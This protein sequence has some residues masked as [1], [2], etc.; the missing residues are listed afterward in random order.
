MPLTRENLKIEVKNNVRIGL[1]SIGQITDEMILTVSD[2]TSCVFGSWLS[3]ALLL[4][5]LISF[6]VLLC[7][8]LFPVG[9][10]SDLVHSILDNGKSLTHFI[11]FHILL[12][13]ELISKFEQIIN[14]GFL[15]IL[16]HFLCLSPCWSL[17]ATLFLFGCNRGSLAGLGRL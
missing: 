3:S 14:F 11:V 2:L 16:L 8:L 6:V 9:L 15:C 13:I 5:L 7:H 10:L 17:G 1:S 12:I 4:L